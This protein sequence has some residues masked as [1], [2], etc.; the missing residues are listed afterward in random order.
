MCW[1]ELFRRIVCTLDT[2]PPH[3]KQGACIPEE[4][5][6]NDMVMS[7]KVYF[8]AY[9]ARCDPGFL[10]WG[11]LEIVLCRYRAAENFL[12]FTFTV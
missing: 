11:V 8:Y 10:S 5:W 9:T 7:G 12:M 1:M 2:K 6:H 4:V 3:T